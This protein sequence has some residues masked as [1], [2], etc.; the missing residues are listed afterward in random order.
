LN[1]EK[2]AEGGGKSKQ[3]AE[4]EAARKGIE[5]KGWM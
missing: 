5:K 1:G 2:I 3:E 4:Q